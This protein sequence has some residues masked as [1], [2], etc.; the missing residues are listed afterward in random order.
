MYDEGRLDAQ[1]ERLSRR[2]GGSSTG[3]AG[4]ASGLSSASA[5]FMSILILLLGFAAFQA[6]KEGIEWAW[7]RVTAG[8]VGYKLQIMTG[9]LILAVGSLFFWLRQVRPT[10]Y[11]IGEVGFGIALGVSSAF[12]NSDHADR[13]QIAFGVIG[14]V[15]LVVRGLDN[16][17]R[18]VREARERDRR[19]EELKQI[20]GDTVKDGRKAAPAS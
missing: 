8:V 17:T 15:Y 14:A 9:V 5:A 4:D 11:G 18:R 16:A 19:A 13:L 1:I 3:Q 6:V 20:R 10:F 7:P 12:P 2:G